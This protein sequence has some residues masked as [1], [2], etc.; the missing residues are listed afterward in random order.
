MTNPIA[1]IEEAQVILVIG[2]NTTENHP[3]LASLH[4][5]GGQAP[6]READRRRPAAHPADPPR[7]ALA[8]AEARHRR[9]LVNGLLHVIFE[10]GLADEEF[11]ARAHRGLRAT[12]ARSSTKYTPEHVEEITGIPAADLVAAARLYAGGPGRE[13]PLH[14]GH[15]PAHHRHRQRQVAREPRDA[16]RQRRRAR[17]RR[18]PAA[19]PE[20]R[21]G[22][23]R[24]GR[25]ARR[26]PRLPAGGERRGARPRWS[27]PGASPS[28][29]PSR[30]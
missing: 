27:R 23:L 30:G 11:I 18:Q 7:D 24:H 9:R 15:H 19:R 22:R 5:A 8:A 10:E 17:R 25:A 2:S 12:C 4:Q 21:P 26:L 16:H 14:D 28:C 1:D 20:Q 6:G 29:P 13:H 3:V